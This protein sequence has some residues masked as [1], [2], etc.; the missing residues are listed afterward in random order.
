[1][2]VINWFLLCLCPHTAKQLEMF[3][4]S[5]IIVRKNLKDVTRVIAKNWLPER[6]TEHSAIYTEP[7]WK[8]EQA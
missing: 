2:Y 1:M 3:V 8:F 7:N 6:G 4:V 5:L